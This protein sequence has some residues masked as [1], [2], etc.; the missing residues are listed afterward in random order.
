MAPAYAGYSETCD[1]VS[2][3]ARAVMSIRQITSKTLS[4]TLKDFEE[5]NASILK[6]AD[7]QDHD[8]LNTLASLDADMLIDAWS[9]PKVTS[10]SN[11]EYAKQIFTD[12]WDNLCY[13]TIQGNGKGSV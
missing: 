12:K 13:K 2:E 3:R 10:E 1:V 8:Y 11:I 6:K 5:M 7:P 4:Q 9:Y